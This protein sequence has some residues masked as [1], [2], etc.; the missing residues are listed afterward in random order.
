MA[1]DWE[2]HCVIFKSGN[3]TALLSLQSDSYGG[4][5]GQGGYRRQEGTELQM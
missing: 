2:C 4:R 5:G 1:R 3:V